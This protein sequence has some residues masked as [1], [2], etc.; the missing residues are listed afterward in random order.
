GGTILKHI[1]RGDEVYWLIVTS[2]GDRFPDNIKDKRNLEIIEVAKQ[3]QFSDVYQLNQ[4]ASQLDSL[5]KGELISKISTV[6]SEVKPNVVY[7]PYP[8]DIHSDHKEVFEA[9]MACTKWF[10]YPHVEKI[11]AYETLSETDF[12]IDPDANGF[13]PN[14]FIN[15]SQYLRKKIE[16]MSIYESEIESFPFPRSVKA[17]ESLAYVRGAASGVDAA[18]A[19]MLLKERI[20]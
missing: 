15:I 16:I 2:M 4:A 12:T 19:F 9:T 6:F 1:S 7:V 17:I 8:S 18:E 13:R 14:V 5:P 20:L 10:R 3:Y 11:L